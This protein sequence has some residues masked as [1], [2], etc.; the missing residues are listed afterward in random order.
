MP[1]IT[2]FFLTANSLRTSTHSLHK[3]HKQAFK[4]EMIVVCKNQDT[5]HDLHRVI[6]SVFSIILRVFEDSIDFAETTLANIFYL[7]MN[8]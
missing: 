2:Q 5:T 4:L 1:K 3:S 6:A 7:V 8:E